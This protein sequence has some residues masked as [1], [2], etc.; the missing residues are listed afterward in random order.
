M[1]DERTKKWVSAVFM[2]ALFL[3]VAVYIGLA[4]LRI[5]TDSSRFSTEKSKTSVN[6]VGYV[7]SVDNVRYNNGLLSFE[8]K[9]ADYSDYEEMNLIIKSGNAT[10]E[11]A[12]IN[13]IRGLKKNIDIEMPIQDNKFST[14]PK[15]CEDD[16]QQYTI[17]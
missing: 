3:V 8:I 1:V 15:S 17:T 2:I 4:M 16:A 7:Y 5:Y 9:N 11:V 14:Y 6:C 13:L 10:K 12:L